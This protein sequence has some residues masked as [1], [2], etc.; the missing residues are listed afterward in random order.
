VGVFECTRMLWEHFL[1]KKTCILQ[2]HSSCL[3]LVG[4]QQ[5]WIF[6]CPVLQILSLWSLTI[7]ERTEEPLVHGQTLS[8]VPA[9]LA[10]RWQKEK[11][12]GRTYSHHFFWDDSECIFMLT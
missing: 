8:S 12:F 2:A 10:L 5:C 11:P 7:W 9:L 4:L 3:T 1:T 6:Y